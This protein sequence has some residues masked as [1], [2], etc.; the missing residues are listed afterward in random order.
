VTLLLDTQ[1]FLWFVLNDMKLSEAARAA[2]E[3][4]ANAIRISPASHWE[5]AI[6]ISLGK[7]QLN[8]PYEQ[9]WTTAMQQSEI[10]VLPIEVRHTA[11]LTTLPFHHKDPF[12]RMLVAQ[13]MV[14]KIPLISS[15][16]TLDAYGVRRLW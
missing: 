3:D 9:F 11:A 14:E 2:I 8:V 13:A 12:D 7:Y 1:C 5:I 10:G 16:S 15:D 4:P 6:K